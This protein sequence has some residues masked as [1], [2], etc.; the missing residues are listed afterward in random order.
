M[1]V[2][3]SVAFIFL[4]LMRCVYF[5]ISSSPP[6]QVVNPVLILILVPVVDTIIYPLIKKCN[7]NFS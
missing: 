5:S 4:S 2:R 1:Q 7:L 3:L 6:P